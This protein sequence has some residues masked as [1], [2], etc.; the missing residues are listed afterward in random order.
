MLNN[1]TLV[2]FVATT[3]GARARSFYSEVLGLELVSDDGF[4][5]VFDANGTRL[6]IQKVE[7]VLPHRYTALGWHVPD[8]EAVV[9]GLRARGVSFDIY[10]GLQQDALS[11][12]TSPSGAKIAWFK[13]P[14]GNV[15]S[16][17]QF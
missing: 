2:A 5:I 1:H 7:D 8:I 13:D 6:R 10:E 3:D 4:A 15:L 14:D 11:I 9:R 12:W 17:S 16:L